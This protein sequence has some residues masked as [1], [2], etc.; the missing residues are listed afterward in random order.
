MGAL[1]KPVGYMINHK[2]H[3]EGEEGI[4]YSYILAADGLWIHASRRFGNGYLGGSVLVGPA[5]VRGLSPWPSNEGL[6]LPY[7]RIPGKL[8]DEVIAEFKAEPRLEHY[9]GIAAADRG[10]WVGP[11]PPA[12]TIV[13]PR[14]DVTG[15][16]VSY[17][18]PDRLVVDIHSHSTMPAFFSHTDT[19]DDDAGFKV[20]IVIGHLDKVPQV[21]IRLGIYGYYRDF[22]N[23]EDVFEPPCLNDIDQ[24]TGDPPDVPESFE[25]PVA[26]EQD[27][28]MFAGHRVPLLGRLKRWRRD[29]TDRS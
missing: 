7:G 1:M 26:E 13:R 29:V 21:R 16:S 6:N 23:W 4:A 11:P 24:L 12:Y 22:L 18:R 28:V 8:W 3:L 19:H 27:E 9:V 2:D 10:P 14:Q 17:D 20:S 25:E 15:A 5:E